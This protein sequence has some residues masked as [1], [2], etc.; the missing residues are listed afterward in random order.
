MADFPN[1]PGGMPD[2]GA[3]MQQMQQMQEDFQ[4][5]LAGK[6]VEASAGGGMVT[7]VISGTRELLRLHI[8]PQVIDP[9]DPQL[10][11]DLVVAAINQGLKKARTLEEEEGRRMAAGLGLPMGMF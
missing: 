5:S 10:L 9:K 7:A 1:F 2:P 8:D 11:Q 4:R 3:L 6:S